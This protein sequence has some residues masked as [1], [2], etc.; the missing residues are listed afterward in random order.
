MTWPMSHKMT[1]ILNLDWQAGTGKSII[2]YQVERQ[3]CTKTEPQF[4]IVNGAT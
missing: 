4:S 2:Q 1:Q 3:T